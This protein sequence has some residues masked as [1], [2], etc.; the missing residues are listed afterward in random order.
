MM[1]P[2]HKAR[3]DRGMKAFAARG[4][5]QP[6]SSLSHHSFKATSFCVM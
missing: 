4:F 2:G 6:F 3:D 5:H 1:G